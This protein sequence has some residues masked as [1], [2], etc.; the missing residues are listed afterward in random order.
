MEVE[1]T[2]LEAYSYRFQQATKQPVTKEQCGRI[3]ADTL[4]NFDAVLFFTTGDPCQTPE[5]MK[6]LLDYVKSG[7]GFLGTH[8]ATDTLYD[9]T[10]YGDMIG[11]YFD[12][13]PWHEKTKIV[14]EDPTNPIVQGLG[15]S[16]EITDELYQFRDPVFARQGP[17]PD[18]SGPGLGGAEARRG[19]AEAGGR[20]AEETR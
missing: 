4:K 12:G 20:H 1:G 14:V 15:D 17:R 16:F 3:N 7:K 10:E 5:E 19:G 9:L 13:H 18:A 2:A 6:A 11:A 8:C